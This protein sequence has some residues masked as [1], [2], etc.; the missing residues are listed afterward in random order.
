MLA[1]L[2]RRASLGLATALLAGLSGCTSGMEDAARQELKA[3]PSAGVKLVQNQP[4]TTPIMPAPGTAVEPA[5]I[6]PGTST[7][8]PL[9]IF[10]AVALA[11]P[12]ATPTEIAMASGNENAAIQGASMPNAANSVT[13]LAI[14]S[15]PTVFPEDVVIAQTIVPTR[16]PAGMLAYASPSTATSLGALDSQFDISAPGPVKVV[17]ETPKGETTAPTVI[18]G[19]IRKYAAIYE[20]PEALV[21]RVVHRESRYNPAAFNGGHYG[22]MQIK[23]ATAKSMGYRGPASGLFDAETNLKYSIKYLRGAWMVADNSNDGA[24]R[25]YA[26]GYYYDAKR[27]GMLHVLK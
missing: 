3:N 27:K 24:V 15:D 14:S 13:T 19:L 12:T 9:P 25:L 22:L 20:I 5:P 26:R 4:A 10:K 17:D 16:R 23:Y 1:R 21:H 8:A 7:P 6:I 2:N 18:N 11:N